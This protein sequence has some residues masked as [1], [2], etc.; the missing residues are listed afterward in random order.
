MEAARAA[1][2]YVI[3]VPDKRTHPDRTRLADKVLDSLE[4]VDLE[5]LGLPPLPNL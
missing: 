4:N 3:M 5:G 1:G 2:M